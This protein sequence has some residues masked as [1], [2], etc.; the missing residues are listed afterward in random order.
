M[1]R[2]PFIADTLSRVGRVK[3]KAGN[4]HHSLVMMP[5]YLVI[6]DSNMSGDGEDVQ[7]FSL[8]HFRECL[9]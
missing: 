9:D 1:Q 3:K 6:P 4:G 7:R 5:Q 8:T 2:I